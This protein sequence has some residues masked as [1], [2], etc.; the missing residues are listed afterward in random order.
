M[1]KLT[2]FLL[3]FHFYALASTL[4]LATSTNPSRLNPILATDSSSSEIAGFIF[5]GLLKYDKD[6]STIIGD[7]AEKFYYESNTS[8]IFELKK[9]VNWHDGEGFTAK[10]V[11]FTYETLVSPK[12]SSPY[13]ANF[14]FVKNVEVIDDYKIRVVYTKPYFKALETWMMGIIPEHILSKEENLMN[15]KF[16]TAPIGTGPY[17][18][19]QLDSEIS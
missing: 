12:I 10:D 19:H 13:S 9:N 5:N 14:R 4:H 2:L 17:K 15:A 7:L 18:L 6:S 1:I 11:L 3:S 16:N 8:V